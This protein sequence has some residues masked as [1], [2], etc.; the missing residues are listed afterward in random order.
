[1][2]WNTKHP[3]RGD[4]PDPGCMFMHFLVKHYAMFKL[5]AL[6]SHGTL[7]KGTVCHRNSKC[8][9][10]QK[11]DSQQQIGNNAA[12]EKR[13]RRHAGQEQPSLQAQYKFEGTSHIQSKSSESK[14]VQIHSDMN[15]GTGVGCAPKVLLQD[16]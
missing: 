15:F 16:A 3:L 13:Q 7:R 8:L 2:S 1:M 4:G 11:S 5:M 12:N 6:W 14:N 10:K 9:G